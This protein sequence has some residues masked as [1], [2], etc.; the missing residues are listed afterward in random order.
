MVGET[1]EQP[2]RFL[3]NSKIYWLHILEQIFLIQTDDPCFCHGY[4]LYASVVFLA[5]TV[6]LKAAGVKLLQSGPTMRQ[7]EKALGHVET[8][9]KMSE[10]ISENKLI[11]LTQIQLCKL[12]FKHV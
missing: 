3:L 9:S 5:S 4:T 12:L 7:V 10:N 11:I 8:A 2:I 6:Q 1:G